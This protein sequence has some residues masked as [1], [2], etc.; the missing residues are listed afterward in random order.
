MTIDLNEIKKIQKNILIA[1]KSHTNNPN[2]KIN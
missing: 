1:T 2:D